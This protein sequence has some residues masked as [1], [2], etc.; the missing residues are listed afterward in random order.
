MKSLAIVLAVLS[1]TLVVVCSAESVEM[2]LKA[3][4]K[5]VSS[6][7]D[8]AGFDVKS[9]GTPSGKGLQ[10]DFDLSKGDWGQV[11]QEIP[12][13]L[14]GIKSVRLKMKLTGQKNR[15]EVKLVD[16]DG[17][18]F[19]AR[20]EDL[21]FSGE[22]QDVVIP[23]SKFEYFWG[24]SD[25][26]LDKA[27]VTSVW[28][29][30]AKM[31]G[32][33]GMVVLDGIR[34][35]VGDGI[36]EAPA[37]EKKDAPASSVPVDVTDMTA[38]EKSAEDG[39]KFD[40]SA[41]GGSL[42]LNYDFAKGNWAQVSRM[43]SPDMQELDAVRLKISQRGSRN[44]VELKLVDADGTNFGCRIEDLPLDGSVVDKVIPIRDLAYFWGGN[45]K[46]DISNLNSVWIAVS[47]MDGGKG[48]VDVGG[49]EWVVKGPT[50][51]AVESKP[52][53][54]AIVISMERA[55]DWNAERGDKA[56][57]DVASRDDGGGGGKSLELKYDLTGGDWIQISTEKQMDLTAAEYVKFRVRMSGM[58]NRVEIK[59]VDV[60]GSNAGYKIEDGVTDNQW[61]DISVSM[62]KFT[63]WWG[64]DDRIDWAKIASVWIAVSKMDGG[65]GTV[66]IGD[67][68]IGQ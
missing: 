56:G 2:D 50:A 63:Y 19:G 21:N 30:V 53:A 29:A 44:R 67:I 28:L 51:S 6:K 64:G 43:V 13:N 60:D 4:D 57:V 62:S 26:V 48:E 14:A 25:Q 3:V 7:A 47:R 41:A 45:D 11:S 54:G 10:V 18:N 38:W 17:T 32:G 68:S 65:K 1:Y 34:L 59:F 5:W 8:G 36:A 16:A 22:W 55:S 24:G 12:L 35:D 37:R 27:Q 66:S 46:L 31:D 42:K 15:I 58:K 39:V 52:A 20:L 49:I 61:R 9:A 23:F 33:K 40:V